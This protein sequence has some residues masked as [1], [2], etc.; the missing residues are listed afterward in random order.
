MENNNTSNTILIIGAILIV[1]L[2]I[3]I[4]NVR[5]LNADIDELTE[6]VTT[7]ENK[8]NGTSS[9]TTNDS[10]DTSAF[11]EI[12]VTDIVT[13][14]KNETIVVWL[15]IPTCGYCQAYAPLLAE[16]ADEYGIV[17]RYVDVTQM[18]QED[19]DVLVSLEGE[20]DYEGFG[21]SFTGTPF[22]MIVKKGKVVGGINGYVETERIESAFAAAGLKK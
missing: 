14:S 18:T 9:N 12:S 8:I 16:V 1:A 15:G 22:T 13:E 17:A 6:R 7:L 3:G 20:G 19:Y 11:K 10:Y 2:V 5:N 4:I 21:A